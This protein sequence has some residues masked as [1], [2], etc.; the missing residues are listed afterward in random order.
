M[1]GLRIFEFANQRIESDILKSR[2][3]EYEKSKIFESNFCI[4]VKILFKKNK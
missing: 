1:T 2:M 4:S 3:P